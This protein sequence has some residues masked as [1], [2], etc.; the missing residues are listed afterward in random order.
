MVYSIIEFSKNSKVCK[1]I[2]N[3][4][5]KFQIYLNNSIAKVSESSNN[6]GIIPDSLG[7]IPFYLE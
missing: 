5:V 1:I 3:H 6:F 7:E 4:L 2:P